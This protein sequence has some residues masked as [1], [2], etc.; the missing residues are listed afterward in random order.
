M[1]D[2]KWDGKGSITYRG[3]TRVYTNYRH[4]IDVMYRAHRIFQTEYILFVS[5][6]VQS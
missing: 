3:K 2:V 4:M 1:L 5:G 6:R